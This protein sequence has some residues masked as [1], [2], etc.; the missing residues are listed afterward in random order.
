MFAMRA[1]GDRLAWSIGGA[2]MVKGLNVYERGEV[3]KTGMIMEGAEKK[4]NVDGST[5]GAWSA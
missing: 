4:I 1:A 3:V 5:G 2:D